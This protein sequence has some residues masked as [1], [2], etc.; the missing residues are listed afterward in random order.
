MNFY[1]T[2]EVSQNASK[3]VIKAAYKSLMQ[4]YHPDKNPDNAEVAAH[5]LQV[6]QAYEVLSDL[7]KRAAYD[8]TLK[9]QLS[10]R[11]LLA[12]NGGRGT[13]STPV[14]SEL[15]ATEENT[16]YWILWM[17]I[18]LTIGFSLYAITLL[19]KEPA[20]VTHQNEAGSRTGAERAQVIPMYVSDLTVE[21]TETDG[22]RGG[23]TRVLVIPELG[24]KVGPLEAEKVSRNLE[25][26][27][28][29]IRKKLE[30][31]L[32]EAKY[33]ELIKADGEKYLKKIIL[34]SIGDIT[35]KIQYESNPS[36]DMDISMQFGVVDVFLPKSFSLN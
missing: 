28:E 6:V 19:K 35:G 33:D 30:E 2:L 7:N 26:N 8:L 36:S 15:L 24:I 11:A 5:A 27:R 21:L 29:I 16:H 31:K 20:P 17:L 25:A 3:E 1:E 4:R 12:G 32:V 14:N 9:Q 18:A 10:D 13:Q 22:F 34:D 23:A